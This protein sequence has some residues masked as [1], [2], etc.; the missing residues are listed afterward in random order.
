MIVNQL[1]R[2]STFE[3]MTFMQFRQILQTFKY[4]KIS[5]KSTQNSFPK[6]KTSK[7]SYKFNSNKNTKIH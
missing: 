6:H 7:Y 4:M 5:E 3:V 2:N 1:K